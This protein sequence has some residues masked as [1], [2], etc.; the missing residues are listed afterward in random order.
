MT[1]ETKELSDDVDGLAPDGC[2]VRLL[3]ELHSGGMAHFQL[4]AGMTSKAVMHKTVEEIWYV[5]SGRA[6]MWRR[7]DTKE[8]VETLTPG[9]C[10]TIPLGTH[11]QFRTVGAEPFSAIGVTIPNWPGEGEAVHVEGPWKPTV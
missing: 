9:V 3:L 8:R 11:F 2:D 10:L 4:D 5:L 6:E 7:A 1:F